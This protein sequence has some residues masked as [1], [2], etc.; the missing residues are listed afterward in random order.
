MSNNNLANNN[1]TSSTPSAKVNK[2]NSKS[3]AVIGG[4]ILLFILILFLIYWFLFRNKS[5]TVGLKEKNVIPYIHDLKIE[6]TINQREIPDSSQGNEYNINFWLFINDYNYKY[7]DRKVIFYKGDRNNI[8]Q[9]NPFVYLKPKE[10]TLVVR[11][12]LQT[13]NESSNPNNMINNSMISKNSNGLNENLN[14]NNFNTNGQNMKVQNNTSYNQG[15]NNSNQGLNNGLNSNQGFNDTQNFNNPNAY[16]NNNS[17]QNGLIE[18]FQN[19]EYFQVDPSPDNYDMPDPNTGTPS[20]N[21]DEGEIK[22]FPLQRW[23]NVNIGVYNNILDISIDG[24][25]EVSRIL[26]GFPVTN[27]GNLRIGS[28]GGANG[29]LSNMTFTNKNIDMDQVEYI[30]SSGPTLQAGLFN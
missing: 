4:V 13:L 30:Y 23:C 2:F 16:S 9:S 5:K 24:K 15:L 1:I 29:Y 26:K 3:P 20:N 6:K 17:T 21:F 27:K 28:D 7:N 11:I 18:P 25:L 12:G 14:S 8:E 19:I 10:N 22:N